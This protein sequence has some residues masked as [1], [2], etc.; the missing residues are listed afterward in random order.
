MSNDTKILT[1]LLTAAD[2]H[3]EDSGEPDHTI[4]DLQDLVKL[5][6]AL[7]TPS[8]RLEVLESDE[9]S[10]LAMAGARDDWDESD[11][12]SLH[13]Q[14]MAALDSR[15]RDLGYTFLE[16]EL[17]VRWE[18]ADE[19]DVEK[20][21]H[22]DA[23]WA[24]YQH[25]FDTRRQALL[26]KLGSDFLTYLEDETG[27]WHDARTQPVSLREHL[28]ILPAEYVTFLKDPAL[29]QAHLEKALP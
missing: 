9:V 20:P 23:L 6:W 7:L 13:Q 25:Y 21:T 5:M 27:L 18:T 24:A 16:T 11:L 17:G 4:G 1:S 29:F 10:D 28:G 8:Q 19:V 3:G 14:D 12:V 2:N 22:D 15:M 26:A